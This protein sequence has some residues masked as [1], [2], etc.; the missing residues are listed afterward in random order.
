MLLLHFV[1]CLGAC[2]VTHIVLWGSS[3]V[4]GVIMYA[5]AKHLNS[6]LRQPEVHVS[7]GPVF[8]AICK[9]LILLNHRINLQHSETHLALNCY[10]HKDILVYVVL[11]V[12]LL[13]EVK[14]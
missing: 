8:T 6:V 13:K 7:T 3:H 9:A 2:Y 1:S 4:L 14:L 10:F 11:S 12:H 5:I